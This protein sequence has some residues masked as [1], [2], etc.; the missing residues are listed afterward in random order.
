VAPPAF[1]TRSCSSVS[2]KNS[3]SSRVTLPFPCSPADSSQH[4]NRSNRDRGTAMLPPQTYSNLCSSRCRPWSSIP[5]SASADSPSHSGHGPRSSGIGTIGPPAS[6]GASPPFREN[7]SW[8]EATQRG[9]TRTSSSVKRSSGARAIL[10][11]AFFGFRFGTCGS[12]GKEAGGDD[13][14]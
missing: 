5:A 3:L 7:S 9:C 6:S 10:I 2:S 11:P 14:R 8:Y 12:P 4:P 13:D 1:R